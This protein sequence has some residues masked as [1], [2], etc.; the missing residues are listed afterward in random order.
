MLVVPPFQCYD[1]DGAP[2]EGGTLGEVAKELKAIRASFFRQL[3]EDHWAELQGLPSLAFLS[4]WPE[5]PSIAAEVQRAN[6]RLADWF[7]KDY[8]KDD[9]ALSKHDHNEGPS[10]QNHAEVKEQQSLGVGA[11][12]AQQHMGGETT[13]ASPSSPSQP[14]NNPA[15]AYA[16]P[17]RRK[18][19]KPDS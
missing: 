8:R 11:E 1:P 5:C 13:A 19:P 7:G 12:G 2:K 6:D 14:A 3:Q 16:R 15:R 17:N 18:R 9:D 4:E 10:L